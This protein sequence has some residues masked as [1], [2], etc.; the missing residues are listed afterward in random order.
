MRVGGGPLGIAYGLRVPHQAL[1]P[2]PRV[3][4]N[5]ADPEDRSDRA[6]CPSWGVPAVTAAFPAQR[7]SPHH[8]FCVRFVSRDVKLHTLQ[9]GHETFMK[10]HEVSPHTEM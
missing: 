7:Q 9:N 3:G 4:L 10:L 5:H 2:V 8:V 1:V 6:V